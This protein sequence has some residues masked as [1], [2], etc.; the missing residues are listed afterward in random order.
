MG[1]FILM[2]RRSN[3]TVG[4]GTF[5]FS[6]R[7]ADNVAWQVL[8]CWRSR[9]RAPA[10]VA[11]S[12]AVTRQIQRGIAVK[13]AHRDQ[14]KT[15]VLHWHHR[16][17]LGPRQMGDADGVPHH[18]IATTDVAIVRGV[19]RQPAAASHSVLVLVRR[20]ASSKSEKL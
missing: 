1:G 18:E 14:V 12:A 9:P 16:P 15:A 13:E 4:V 10:G 19:G 2:D 20:T 11:A 8:A 7:R 17:V 3:A 5:D 6:L